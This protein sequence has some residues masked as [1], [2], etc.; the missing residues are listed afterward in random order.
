MNIRERLEQKAV[1]L[2]KIQAERVAR[3]GMVDL[4]SWAISVVVGGIIT[5]VALVA[6]QQQITAS[7]GNFSGGAL[8]LIGLIVFVL[9]A[10]F[11]KKVFQ[12]K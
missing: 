9:V 12:S 1:E 8:A 3:K 5:V 6:L 4:G 11:I 2:K 10:V 7:S